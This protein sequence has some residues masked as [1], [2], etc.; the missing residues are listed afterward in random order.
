MSKRQLY[1]AIFIVA[2]LGLF[3]VQYQYLKIGLNLATVQF[4]KNIGLASQDIKQDL[5]TENQLSFLVGQAITE[6][7]S[8]FDLSL[9]SIQDA[10]KHFLND[11]ITHRLSVHGIDKDFSYRLFTRDSSYYLKSNRDLKSRTDLVTVSVELEGYLPRLL[12]KSVILELQFENLNVYFLSQ[13]NGLTI[14]SFILI[15]VI[16]IIFIWVLR[17]VYWQNKVI[18]TTNAFINNLTHELKTPVFSIG[19]ATKI[20]EDGVKPDKKPIIELIRQ[21]VDRL[22]M[23]IDKVLELGK[24]EF[25]KSLFNLKYLDFK[26][27]LL[28][29][30]ENFE[31]LASLESIQFTYELRDE[32][33]KIRAEA[34][35]LENTISNILDNAKKYSE[36]PK[37]QLKA[38]KN[39][40]QL[41][42]SVTDNGIG[43]QKSDRALI[44]KKY[45]RVENGNLHKT[46][47]YGLGLSYVKEV[48]K[49]HKGKVAIE[50]KPN[51]GTIVTI[52]LPL[53]YGN[54]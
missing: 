10:S 9:D 6:N 39:K 40:K 46:K 4:N 45:Y 2:I 11:F 28:N 42:I 36:D 15:M 50:S 31:A 43:I 51:H 14:P 20:L 32:D 5:I 19:L 30:C 16:I 22:N 26:P 37:I 41:I 34:N 49:K 8:Y 12:E 7:D 38:Y 29:L 44:F 48:I 24:L 17:S 1:I 13:L 53:H 23:H 47:G 25:Q 3:V 27:N 35:H 54:K 21:Q 18:T 33:Y 52:S